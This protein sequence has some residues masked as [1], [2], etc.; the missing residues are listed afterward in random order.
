MLPAVRGCL[1]TLQVTSGTVKKYTSLPI[2][3]SKHIN[4]FTMP[5][6]SSCECVTSAYGTNRAESDERPLRAKSGRFAINHLG[7][8]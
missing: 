2:N 7:S 8:D 4:H 3:K 5:G 6:S 1:S